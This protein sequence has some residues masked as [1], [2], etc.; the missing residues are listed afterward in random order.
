MAII[1]IAQ[2]C[3]EPFYLFIRE[4]RQRTRVD[5]YSNDILFAIFFLKPLNLRSGS[6]TVDAPLPCKVLYQHSP[7]HTRRLHIDESLRLVYLTTRRK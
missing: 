1:C 2:F 6:R 3:T 5:A 4:H 7:C